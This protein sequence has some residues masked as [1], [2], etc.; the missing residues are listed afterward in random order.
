MDYSF[1]QVDVFTDHI[2]GGNALAVFPDAA[3]LSDG[4]MQSLAGEM[5]LS[6]TTFVLP[7]RETEDVA[8]VRIFTPRQ[9]LPFAG[10]PTLG[11]VF[12]LGRLG[13]LT[14]PEFSLE[15]KIGRIP[16]R[17]EGPV[18]HPRVIWM[19]QPFPSFGPSI[20]DRAGIAARLGLTVDDLLPVAA[21]VGGPVPFM[22]V[23]LRTP[24][25]VDHAALQGRD[26]STMP[27]AG[28]AQGV[29][30]FSPRPSQ[31]GYA[32]WLYGGDERAGKRAG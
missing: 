26:L 16:I 4:Q 7:P 17:I 28:D 8:S 29:F 23:A 21:R 27:G 15:E 12:I 6:E 13:R 14:T 22:F 1:F 9:E 30:L 20:E 10:H 2:F 25:A 18:D 19:R 5:N 24:E 3:G 32:A 11:T 31:P